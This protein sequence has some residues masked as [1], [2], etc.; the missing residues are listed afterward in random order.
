VAFVY[1]PIN[2]NVI[3]AD[4]GIRKVSVVRLPRHETVYTMTV[5]KSQ[6]SEFERI[7]LLLPDRDS[8]GLTRELIYT[9][10]TRAKKAVEIWGKDSSFITAVSRKVDRSSGLE[11]ALWSID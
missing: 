2:T 3:A 4:G 11:G 7:L 8:E 9:A 6:G 5:H 10:V 1:I